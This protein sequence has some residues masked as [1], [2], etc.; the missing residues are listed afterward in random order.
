[1]KRQTPLTITEADVVGITPI[2]LLQA[3]KFE[4]SVTVLAVVVQQTNNADAE[5]NVELDGNDLFSAEQS[6]AAA[7]TPE[8]FIPDQSQDAHDDV[9]VRIDVDVSTGAAN[10][11]DSLG[12]SVLWDDGR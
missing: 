11:A 7:D 8:E 1:M 6:V 10:A 2:D 9:G 3:Y 12:V 4:G 5:W